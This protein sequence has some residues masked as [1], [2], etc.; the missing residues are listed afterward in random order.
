MDSKYKKR[1]KI[2]SFLSVFL[3]FA[4]CNLLC[5]TSAPYAFAKSVKKQQA[6]LGVPT[7]YPR[8][9]WSNSKYEKRTKEIWPAEYETP[10]VVI[11]HHT[12]TN[13]KSSTSKQIKK[14]Y[15]Y[16][17][18]TRKWGDIGYNYIIGK[19]GA[20]FE[21]RYGGNG[22][23]GGHSYYNKT[24]YNSGSIGIAVL[25]NYVGE[26]LS[27]ESLN[28]LQKLIGWL[29]ANNSIEIKSEIRFHGKKLDSAVVGHKD[30]ADT[31]CPGKNIY[32]NLGS[33]RTAS[34]SLADTF[35]NYAYR[36]SESGTIYEIHGG[37]KYSG[38]AK[39]PV[40]E[41][42]STQLAAYATNGE[43]RISSASENYPSWTLFKVSGSDQ[44]GI[45]ENGAVRP[46][47][48]SAV[49]SENYNSA[50][51]VEISAAKWASYPAGSAA[52][53]RNGTFLSDG[54][55]NYYIISEGVKKL[56]ALPEG[57]RSWIEYTR[58]QIVSSAELSF[59]PN[60]E[61]ITSAKNLPDGT[62]ITTGGRNYFYLQSGATK[63]KISTP[64]FNASFS[65][66]M[67]VKVS[68]KLAKLYKTRGN[69]P[70]QNGA[71]VSYNKKYYFIENGKRRKFSQSLADSMGY[72]NIQKAKRSEMSG[73]K[74]G[75]RIE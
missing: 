11:V 66:E 59:Y 12:A 41:I 39:Q 44:R 38:S 74:D 22:V 2:F 20:I 27:A 50:N 13:Y 55:G 68:Q 56:L 64:V 63:R 36:T 25:G 7:I 31:A 62:I 10:E 51:L 61:N 58:A 14:I 17:S 40:I 1:E 60:G 75:A 52:A 24:N 29:S 18:Y 21:G 5:G 72:K 15:R 4:I 42:S 43:A 54:T 9:S 47:A 28:A 46:I 48:S 37:K 26:K 69:L 8:S 35:S 67:V 70:F 3:L 19:D 32:N 49:L 57:E 30:V 73:I 71:V 23:V 16:H 65:S 6:S 33:I 34:A 45:L 53:F